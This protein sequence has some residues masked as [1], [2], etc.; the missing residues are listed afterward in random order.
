MK[1]NPEN[2]KA[3][4]DYIQANPEAEIW[5]GFDTWDKKFLCLHVGEL[6][7]FES[8]KKH[9]SYVRVT[10]IT[11]D[12]PILPVPKRGP[13][14]KSIKWGDLWIHPNCSFYEDALK[15]NKKK[16]DEELATLKERK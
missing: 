4:L 16:V 5:A 15:G 2:C 12:A 11:E 14:W 8:A 6:G 3:W 7:E 13:V 10:E 1:L 9:V